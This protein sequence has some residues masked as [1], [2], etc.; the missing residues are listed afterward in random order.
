MM[1]QRRTPSG[2]GPS[3]RPSAGARTTARGVTRQPGSTRTA[4][5]V[6]PASRSGSRPAA[7]RR[8]T[9]T[10]QT[11]RTAP[12]QPRR[13]TGRATILLVVLGALAL[14]YTYPV[15][16][17]LAQESAIAE[18]EALSATKEAKIRELAEEAAKWQDDQYVR[19]QARERFFY[20][21][22]GEA[23]LIVIM[24]PA[25]AARDANKNKPAQA[26]PSRWYDT[27]LSSV[28]AADGRP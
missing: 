2:Q 13:F 20:V 8:Q 26:A 4:A 28:E 15:R 9:A 25:G 10:G 21:K 27:L 11:R 1:T 22:P 16:V 19:T 3:R 5:R 17:Y 6:V 14:G 18:M 24:D 23:P 12:P 7:A